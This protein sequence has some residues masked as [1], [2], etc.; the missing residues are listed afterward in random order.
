[1]PRIFARLPGDPTVTA[2]LLLT[3]PA[4]AKMDASWF[5]AGRRTYE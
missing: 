3:T 1:M 4:Q 5:R 2:L